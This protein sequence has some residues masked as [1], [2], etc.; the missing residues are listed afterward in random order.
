M[1]SNEAFPTLASFDVSVDTG[2]IPQKTPLPRL[3]PY[4]QKWEEVV[5]KLALLLKEKRLREVVHE[6]P[7]QEFSENTLHSTEEWRRALVVLSGLFQGYLWQEGETGVP[8]K[9]PAILAVP[10]NTVSRN[11]GVPPVG[12]YASFSLYNWGLRDSSQPMTAD[13]MYALVTHTGTEDE[14][15]FF[16]VALLVELEAVPA[17]NA[18]MDAIVARAEGNNLQIINCLALIESALAS[19]QHAINRMFERCNP[20]IFY[21]HIRPYLAGSKGLDAFPEGLLY[22]GVDSTPL[23]FNGS[24]AAQ[25]S[26]IQAIDAVLGTQHKG[27]DAEFL[28]DMRSYMPAKHRG[29]VE[30]ISQQPSLRQYIMESGDLELVQQYN[31]TVDAFVNYRSNHIILVTRYIVVQRAHSVTTSLELKGTGGTNFMQFLKMIR[32]N[33]KSLKISV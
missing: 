16:M 22:E 20:T 7:A 4:F 9:M 14:S 17:L 1:S 29:F 28:K 23:R 13:N 8:T 5:D 33:T 32:D 31:S 27:A 6:L 21:V 2:F 3:P 18:I 19:M 12:T 25:S 24:S 26:A 15:W 30:Y 11:I 10:L